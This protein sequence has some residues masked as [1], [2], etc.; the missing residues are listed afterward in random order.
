[1]S[2]IS[3]IKEWM[4]NS[5]G[6][7]LFIIG[8]LIL[9]LLIPQ[10]MIQGLVRERSS[11]QEEAIQ[12]ICSKWAYSQTING[13][14]LTV[15]YFEYDKT[16][17]LVAIKRYAHF[18]PKKLVIDGKIEPETRKRGIYEVVVY[19]ANLKIKGSFDT[20]QTDFLGINKESYQWQNAFLSIGI[21]DM[22]GIKKKIVVK[23][24]DVSS[25]MNPGI[26]TNEVLSSGVSCPVSTPQTTT[27]FEIDLLL[28]GSENL[29]FT[30]VGEETQVH[31]ASTWNSPSFDGSFLP[32]E[33]KID[34]NGF[35]A[36]W[37]VLH[38]NRNFPQ[39]WTNGENISLTDSQFG[40]KL[41]FPVDH[42]KKTERSA[43]YA[44]MFIFLTFVLIFFFERFQ[45]RR[46]HF[47]QYFFIGAALII[48]YTLLL[49]LS[50][51]IDFTIAYLIAST[52]TISLISAY[53][54]SMVKSFKSTAIL[55]SVLIL[56]YLFLFTTLQIE[57]YSLLIGSIGIFIVL[58]VLMYISR[59]I[60]WNSN[61]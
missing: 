37:N 53:T 35:T 40:V 49:S 32:D 14:I 39:Q 4:K 58:S 11:Y 23:W 45:K 54:Y 41:M 6:V 55:S 18:L 33:R 17:P 9:L 57:D 52:A 10:A 27:P 3:E 46:I 5:S 16:N 20:L 26:P 1:M 22:R 15:P 36:D 59:K 42:Y 51:Y 47:I 12:D 56:L 21:D 7:K 61:S 29:Y 31:I 28:N 34:N 25:E 24:G 44:I 38:L 60:E 30:P 19:K 48:F 2:S 13:P 50:E 43:K 8:V